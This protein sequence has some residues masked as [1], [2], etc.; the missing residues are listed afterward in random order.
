MLNSKYLL[1]IYL[2]IY[3]F[4]SLERRII[5][6]ASVYDSFIALFFT[7]NLTKTQKRK[8]RKKK[9]TENT[10]S[11]STEVNSIDKIDKVKLKA[12]KKKKHRGS[13]NKNG[14]VL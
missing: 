9:I 6:P 10:D 1:T 8:L 5:L 14:Y 4:H 13:K 2:G 3:A 11:R 7:S 12:K